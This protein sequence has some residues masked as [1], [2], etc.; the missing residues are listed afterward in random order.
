MN[1]DKK[2]W[3]LIAVCTGTFMLLLDITI[4]NVALPDIQLRLGASFGDLQ[5]VVDAYALSLASLLL[6]AGSLADRFGRRLLFSIGLVIF[7]LGSLLCGL[8]QSPAMLIISRAIQGVGGA[9]MFATSLALLAHSFR[10]RE[11]GTAFGVWGATTGVATA[12]GPI[13]GGVITSGISW[14]GIFLVNVPIGIVAVA[15]TIWRVEESK[16]GLAH[17]PDW[18]GCVLF[19]G[20]LLSLVYGLIRAGEISWSNTGVWICLA[21]AVVL[22]LAFGVVERTVAHPMF[23]LSLFRI[24]TFVGGSIAA[25]AMNGSLFAMLLY[26]T[27]YM[28]DLL[29]L[30]PLQVGVRFLVLSV[31]TLLVATVTGRL[32]AHVPVRLLVGPGLL[33]VGIGLL[34]TARIGAHSTWTHLIPGF[35]LGGIGAGMVNPPLASTAVG[36]VEPQRSGMA[37]G[38]NTTFRQVGIAASIAILGSVFATHLT[39]GITNA[40][41]SSSAVRRAVTDVHSGYV[42]RAITSVPASERAH[43]T[44]V[45]QS[46]FASGINELVIIAGIIALIG[47]MASLA[48]IR[49]QD[50]VETHAPSA[51]GTS[52]PAA[53]AP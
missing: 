2:W 35:I 22:L 27:L 26:F 31:P 36:V 23:D 43:L 10:G 38:I 37:S 14:R 42:G 9:I 47:G 41:G 15:I 39:Q 50:F 30:S 3:T 33:I 44:S 4:V 40:M 7:T 25:L 21:L 8:A 16:S 29:G 1:M 53:P 17:R 12:L 20:G 24:P 18:L 11:R 45:I 51:E 48:L 46:T 34:L 13:L 5:W 19:T 28:Q 6:T 49:G 32:S 52:T